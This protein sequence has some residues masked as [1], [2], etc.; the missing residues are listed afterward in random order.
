MGVY[1]TKMNQSG[2]LTMFGNLHFLIG[3]K[4]HLGGRFKN[5]KEMID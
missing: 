2:N 3:M 5:E 1:I 4:I